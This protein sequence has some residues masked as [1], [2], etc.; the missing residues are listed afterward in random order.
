MGNASLCYRPIASVEIRG[1]TLCVLNTHLPSGE[2]LDAM[3]QRQQALTSIFTTGFGGKRDG[4]IADPSSAARPPAGGGS[5]VGPAASSGSVRSNLFEYD[6]VV[7]MGDMNIRC[8]PAHIEYDELQKACEVGDWGLLQKKDDLS[9]GLKNWRASPWS[10]LRMAPLH[11]FSEPQISHPPTYKFKRAKKGAG[12]VGATSFVGSAIEQDDLLSQESANEV[13]AGEQEILGTPEGEGA[14]L[15]SA[16]SK[17]L[18]SSSAPANVE[19]DQA[20]I[21]ATKEAKQEKVKTIKIPIPPDETGADSAGAQEQPPFDVPDPLLLVPEKRSRPAHT[22]RIL[23]FVPGIERKNPNDHDLLEEQNPNDKSREDPSSPDNY[24]SP[25]A[26]TFVTLKTS[27]QQ[28]RRS[29]FGGGS[30]KKYQPQKAPVLAGLNADLQKTFSAYP[31]RG[32]VA[33]NIVMSPY[34][35]CYHVGAVSD[36]LPVGCIL[37]VSIQK[38]KKGRRHLVRD[39]RDFCVE[40]LG[41][42]LDVWSEHAHPELRK[43]TKKAEKAKAGGGGGFCGCGGG[44]SKK[45]MDDLQRHL[46]AQQKEGGT[47]NTEQ[48]VVPS[49]PPRTAE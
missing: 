49:Q 21:S 35:V 16:A 14:V 25:A 2:G 48:D 6:L 45:D 24:Y 44:A 37:T 9:G 8:C 15:S 13:E 27:K 32:V 31:A 47:S 23:F 30:T 41:D 42:Y 28:S 19:N 7:C 36:H 1:V 26:H 43:A 22:D 20:N 4:D 38:G 10:D 46:D 40:S 11:G 18:D 12:A 34:A 17:V 33:S 29:V 5:K 39:L 3:K